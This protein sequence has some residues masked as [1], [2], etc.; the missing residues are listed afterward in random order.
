MS[1]LYERMIAAACSLDQR[2]APT[3]PE[4][5]SGTGKPH[6]PADGDRPG[7]L[8]NARATWKDILEPHNW[9]FVYER[10]GLAFWRRPGKTDSGISAS[11]GVRALCGKDLLHIFTT[12]GGALEDNK[13]YSKFGAY[14]ALNHNGDFGA[15]AKKLRDDGYCQPDPL[16][17]VNLH[18]LPPAPR[19]NGHAPKVS[20][21]NSA[22]P[23]DQDATAQDL[24]EHN[25][26]IRWAWEKWLPVGVLTILASEPGV[27][28]TRF[29][30]DLARRIY[31]GLPWPDGAPQTLPAKSVTLWVPADNQHPELG[32]IPTAF[33]FP[34]SALY[35]NTTR[36]EPFLGTMLDTP[37]DLKDF[38]A[39]IARIKPAIV[40]VDTCLNATDKTSHKPEDAKAFF[41][42]LQQIAARQQI[43]LVCVTHL[44]A[45]GKPLGRRISGQGR[46]VIQLECPDPE[47][48][49]NRRKLHVVKSNSLF[50]AIMG[51]TMQ[52]GGNEYDANPPAQRDEPKKGSRAS[53]LDADCEWLEA[54]LKG[55]PQR[56]SNTRTAAETHGI[57]SARLYNAKFHM[58][59]EEYSSQGKKWWKLTAE[60]E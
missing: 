17:W 27:G 12:N 1:T 3:E 49:P 42:P 34:P 32:S 37:E 60:S 47:N 55:G 35:L 59:I 53:H 29:C 57:G 2:P 9:V 16:I 18:K 40:F 7:D 26:T 48:H 36:R 38:E 58:S 28:K 14:A 10:G 25:S 4:Y 33:G 22:D 24:I 5:T 41:V 51:V 45:S 23:L 13:N 54:F 56:V 30:C 21:G 44:N 52:D 15:A 31:L 11:T 20:A 50:P 19:A 46:I 43:V 6:D 8:F 39:R